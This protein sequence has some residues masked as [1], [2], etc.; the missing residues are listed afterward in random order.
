M[1]SGA[2]QLQVAETKPSNHHPTIVI[3]AMN[4]IITTL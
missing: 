4:T 2:P 1:Q 3:I